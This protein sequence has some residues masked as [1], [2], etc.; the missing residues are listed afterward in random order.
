M[1]LHKDNGIKTANFLYDTRNIV[2]YNWFSQKVMSRV[3]VNGPGDW[4]SIP[5][6]IIP[7]I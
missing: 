4:D 2:I 6:W 1:C 7:K 5:G 3:F